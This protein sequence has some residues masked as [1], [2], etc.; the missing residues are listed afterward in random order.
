MIEKK[1]KSQNK[2]ENKILYIKIK[3]D[4]HKII[5]SVIKKYNDLKLKG[6]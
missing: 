1:D 4:S 5:I 6:L 3:L 2:I